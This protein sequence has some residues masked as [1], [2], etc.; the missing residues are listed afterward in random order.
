MYGAEEQIK[1]ENAEIEVWKNDL[2]IASMLDE[3]IKAGETFNEYQARTG[4]PAFLQ[5]RY[6]TL[7]RASGIAPHSVKPKEDSFLEGFKRG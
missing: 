7:Q 3:G 4:C 6:L 2:Q 1:R 5:E